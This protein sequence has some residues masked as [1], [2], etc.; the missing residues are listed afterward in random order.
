MPTTEQA[1]SANTST[2]RVEDG[3]TVVTTKESTISNTTAEAGVSIAAYP[4]GVE[5]VL[6][7]DLMAL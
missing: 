6:C 4:K 1:T 5:I 7:R 2:P 3:S